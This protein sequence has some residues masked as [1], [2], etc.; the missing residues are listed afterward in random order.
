MEDPALDSRAPAGQGAAMAL[1]DKLRDW[2]AAGLIDAEA[3]RRIAAH[4]GSRER[5]LVRWALAGL[6]LFA[7][8][9][10]LLLLVAAN[11]AR[12]PD[13]VKLG[14][15]GVLTAATALLLIR[16]HRAGETARQEALL[17]ILGAI[18]MAGIFLWAQVFVLTGPLWR[19]LAL[20]LALMTA[21]LLLLGRTAWT[22]LGWALVAGLAA[23]ALAAEPPGTGTARLLAQGVAMATPALLIAIAATR[24]GPVGDALRAV[25]LVA[26]LAGAGVAHFAWADAITAA[27][28]RDMAIRLIPAALATALALWAVRHTDSLPPALR[29]PLLFGPLVAVALATAL[30]HPDAWGSRLLGVLLYAAL[31]GSIAAAAARTGWGALFGIAIA[32]LALRLFII[33]LEL[34]GSMATTGAGLVSG[35]LLLIALAWGW[36]RIMRT[37]RS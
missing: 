9:L 15:H 19:A 28:A 14:G 12:I 36:Q 3:A 11:W 2:V 35:G 29:L 8:G 31:W 21:P 27:Q 13:A 26:L 32:A 10:G 33:Y 24:G 22:A 20:W 6:G 17:V 4:E 5:P 23:I 25:G 37:A 34:F 18:V 30:P 1:D 16:A 7:V